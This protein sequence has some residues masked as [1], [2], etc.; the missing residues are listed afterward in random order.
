MHYTKE[1]IPTKDFDLM[2]ENY[3][4]SAQAFEEMGTS[5]DDE[6]VSKS[7]GSLLSL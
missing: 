2:I 6:D 7:S 3:Q 4:S 1:T 5:T